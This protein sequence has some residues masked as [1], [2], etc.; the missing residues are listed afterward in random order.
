MKKTDTKTET[1]CHCGDKAMYSVK[2]DYVWRGTVST[3]D[4]KTRR[5]FSNANQTSQSFCE[6]CYGGT[7]LQIEAPVPAV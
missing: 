2:I 3:P 6:G 1:R 5:V 7:L 4:G